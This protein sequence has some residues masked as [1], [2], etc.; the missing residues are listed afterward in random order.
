M[1]AY[2]RK[3]DEGMGSFPRFRDYGGLR[4]MLIGGWR[5]LGYGVERGYDWSCTRSLAEEDKGSR[6]GAINKRC[7]LAEARVN[8]AK[9]EVE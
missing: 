6:S 4:T 7:L 8:E 9:R 2:S 1:I 3:G 5:I